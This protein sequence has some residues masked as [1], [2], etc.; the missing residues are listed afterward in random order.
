M[1]A[2]KAVHLLA[3]LV[4]I[5]FAS[6]AFPQPAVDPLLAKLNGFSP[7]ERQAALVKG[8]QTER[9]VEWYATLP[10]EHSKVLIEA[11]R[12]RYPFIEVKYTGAGGGRMINR[13]VTEHRAGLNKFDVLGGTS[14]S[15]VALMKAGLIARNMS[16]IRKEV[17]DGFRDADGSGVAPFT[18]ALVIGYNNRAVP[19]DQRPRS[20]DD[21]LNARWKGQIGLEAA[22]YEWLAAMIDTMGEDKALAFARKLASQDLKVQQGRSLLGKNISARA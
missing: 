22:G 5:C 13:V 6:T 9:A 4:L 11:F 12:Q 3:T 8:A 16:P 17:R 2:N 10:V 7:D 19:K 18:S 14:T 20:Y 1:N 21:L 15:H